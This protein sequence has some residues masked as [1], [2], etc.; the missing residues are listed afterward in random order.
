MTYLKNVTSLKYDPEKCT[1]CER[2]TEVCPH[3]VFK[4]E[5]NRAVITDRDRCM[6]CGACASN[7]AY[8][9]ISVN[10]GVGC[11]YAMIKGLLRYGDMDQ[12]ECGCGG[13]E[14][15]GKGDGCC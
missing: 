11:A 7:C 10:P 15:D 12:A 2:C 3:R 8:G 5:N 13:G 6:E 1:G 9:A 14:G 4:M